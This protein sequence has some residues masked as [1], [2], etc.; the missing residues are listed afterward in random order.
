SKG[1]VTLIPEGFSIGNL[2]RLNFFR[3]GRFSLNDRGEIVFLANFTLQGSTSQNTGIF[4]AVN[5]YVSMI[6]SSLDPLP[7]F[8]ENYTF[9]G[10]EFGHD[11]A[12]NVYFAVQ[13][14]TNRAIYRFSEGDGFVKVV[15]TGT[16]FGDNT[17]QT[18]N[19][20]LLSPKGSVAFN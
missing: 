8:P 20:F 12:G 18:V 1:Q 19:R 16:V 14:G 3:V 2:L 4:R 15:G 5:G 11:G 10:R 6:W 7:D 13:A 9:D 17:I